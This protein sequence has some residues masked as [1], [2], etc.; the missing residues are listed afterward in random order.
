MKRRVPEPTQTYPA[1]RA[2]LPPGKGRQAAT[3]DLAARAMVEIEE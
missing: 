2:F 3:L 1:E